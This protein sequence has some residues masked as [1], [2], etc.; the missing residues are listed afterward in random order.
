MKKKAWLVPPL[1]LCVGGILLSVRFLY[2]A[3]SNGGVFNLLLAIM[4]FIFFLFILLSVKSYLKNNPA[5]AELGLAPRPKDV[6]SH[7]PRFLMA[8]K[9]ITWIWLAMMAVFFFAT[10]Y[11]YDLP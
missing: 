11:R 1:L 9:I 8:G 10:V 5:R 7:N 2:L 6:T 3:I 4:T